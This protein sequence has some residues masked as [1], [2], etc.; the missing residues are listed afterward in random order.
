[1]KK[2]FSNYFKILILVCAFSSLQFGCTS[3]DFY[4]EIRE[5]V[6]S[7]LNYDRPLGLVIVLGGGGSRGIAHL[8]VLSVLQEA[9]IKIDLIVGCSAGAIIGALY[10]SHL[11]I[12]L[13]KLLLVQKNFDDL[14]EFDLLQLPFALSGGSRLKI[15]L[16]ENLSVTDFSKLK[17]PLAVVATDLGSGNMTV[18]NDGELLSPLIASAAIPGMFAPVKLHGRRFVDCGVTSPIPVKVAKDLS[19]KMVIAVDIN[20]YLPKAKPHHFM[21][22]M[23]RSLEISYYNLA[24]MS[25]KEADV[26]IDVPFE[27]TGTFTDD[28]GEEF[29]QLGRKAALKML[30]QIKALVKKK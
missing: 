27:T 2:T 5:P 1:M 3:L 6:T 11:N 4:D 25:R 12:D 19:A 23:K 17:I 29:Y 15:F 30:P 14:V 10:S 16:E 22:I 20:E 18:F 26:V 7:H 24:K 9:N 21:G 8:G 13:I 28:K